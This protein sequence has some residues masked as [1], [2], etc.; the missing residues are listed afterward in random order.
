[1]LPLASS[2]LAESA[3]TYELCGAFSRACRNKVSADSRRPANVSAALVQRLGLRFQVIYD[4]RE[5]TLAGRYR[6][7]DLPATF[8]LDKRG[9]IRWKSDRA[10]R[11]SELEAVLDSLD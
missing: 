11:A 8:V 1:M 9:I 4:G 5:R 6:V 7:G 3:K 10:C 2:K